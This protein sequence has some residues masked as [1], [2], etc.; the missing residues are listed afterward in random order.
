MS[1]VCFK[2]RYLLRTIYLV[3]KGVLLR[4]MQLCRLILFY[5]YLLSLYYVLGIMLIT[6]KIYL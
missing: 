1:V 4:E 6:M 3:L 2:G 5:Y